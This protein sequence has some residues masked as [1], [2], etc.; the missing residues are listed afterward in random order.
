LG[1]V[2]NRGSLQST[3]VLIKTYL[4]DRFFS[5][6]LCCKNSA[7]FN[8]FTG[9]PSLKRSTVSPSLFPAK[10]MGSPGFCVEVIL[11]EVVAAKGKYHNLVNPEISSG[12][13]VS[14]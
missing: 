9:M 2:Q 10:T 11:R 4:I 8:H 14:A 3:A 5:A 12:S 13:S 6:G 7:F 1:V